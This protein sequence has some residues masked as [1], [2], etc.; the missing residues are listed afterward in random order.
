M[1]KEKKIMVTFFLFSYGTN[2]LISRT[3]VRG[4]LYMPNVPYA[5][6]MILEFWVDSKNGYLYGS[7]DPIVL[8]LLFYHLVSLTF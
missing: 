3:I 7:V 8:N 2:Q 6:D 4:Y 5:K 1:I